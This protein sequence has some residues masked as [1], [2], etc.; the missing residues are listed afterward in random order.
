MAS[1]QLAPLFYIMEPPVTAIHGRLGLNLLHHVEF[2]LSHIA[3]QGMELVIA[4]KVAPLSLI[5]ATFAN[6]STA[7]EFEILFPLVG[8]AEV[9]MHSQQLS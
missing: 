7:L 4:M 3:A 6:F 1:L 2:A 9:R 8:Q 5:L